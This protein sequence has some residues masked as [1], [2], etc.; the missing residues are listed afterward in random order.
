MRNAHS[1]WTGHPASLH[2][3]SDYHGGSHLYRQ[4]GRTPR[5]GLNNRDDGFLIHS[6]TSLAFDP[7]SGTILVGS[8]HSSGGPRPLP[9]TT[10]RFKDSSREL[11]IKRLKERPLFSAATWSTRVSLTQE[12]LPPGLTDQSSRSNLEARSMGI[13]PGASKRSSTKAVQSRA[14]RDSPGGSA[15]QIR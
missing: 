8:P 13:V 2:P 7:R 12:V 14:G 9:S 4:M 10:A 11:L 6:P 3:A 15:D 1:N 5:L